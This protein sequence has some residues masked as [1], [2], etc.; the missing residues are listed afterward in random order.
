MIT[1]D[2]SVHVTT[3]TTRVCYTRYYRTAGTT[4]VGRRPRVQLSEHG[5]CNTVAC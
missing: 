4:V 2:I 3:Y 5:T 1:G